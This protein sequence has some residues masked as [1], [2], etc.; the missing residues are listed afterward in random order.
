MQ[1]LNRA[2]IGHNRS[3]TVGKIVRKNA[4][5]FEFDK[6]VGVHNGTLRNKWVLEKHGDYDTD[7][8]ALYAN[9]NHYGV[10]AAIEKLDGAYTLVWY[11]KEDTT[12]NFLRNKERPLYVVFSKDKKLVFWASEKWM[13]WGPLARREIVLD[14][15]MELPI[16]EHWCLAIPPVQQVFA[17][18]IK[19]EVKTGFFPNG[20]STAVGSSATTST[21]T[22]GIKQTKGT[23]HIVSSSKD[24]HPLKGKNTIIRPVSWSKSA[25]G[26][27][28]IDA[29][30]HEFPMKRFKIYAH[31][32]EECKKVMELKRWNAVI[33]GLHGGNPNCYKINILSLTKVEEENAIIKSAVIYRKD[34]MNRMISQQEF[35]ERYQ[36]CSFCGGELIFDTS[37]KAHSETACVCPSCLNDPEIANYLPNFFN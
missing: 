6:V 10:E 7:S 4:H 36:E 13:L 15:V 35:K 1:G 14:E 30:A 33:G 28:V 16:D 19:K 20:T 34:H 25:A 29:V 2:L 22:K 24:A 8:E 27:Y 26:A 17:D 32:P 5:P 11:D 3:A 12:I 18:P 23:L 31:D 21:G 37:W 9:I